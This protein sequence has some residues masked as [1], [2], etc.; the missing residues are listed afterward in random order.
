MD[1]ITDKIKQE[2]EAKN[3]NKTAIA[4]ELG[5]ARESVY[6]LADS[7]IKLITFLKLCEILKRPVSYFI[8]EKMKIQEISI[9]QEPDQKY[10]TESDIIKVLRNNIKAQELTIKA[11]EVTIGILQNQLAPKMK[12]EKRK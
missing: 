11:Q 9:V 7:S 3:L 8:N 4:R 5:M 10:G 6:N 1:T 12:L 2:I